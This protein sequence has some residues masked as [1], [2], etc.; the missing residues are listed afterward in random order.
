MTGTLGDW[1]T[2][3]AIN[4]AYTSKVAGTAIDLGNDSKMI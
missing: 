1:R 3:E 4:V 2:S